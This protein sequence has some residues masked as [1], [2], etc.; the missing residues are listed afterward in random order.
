MS[1][2][3]LYRTELLGWD[4][5][6][7]GQFQGAQSVFSLPAIAVVGPT[8]RRCGARLTVHLGLASK[9]L[10]SMLT[11]RATRGWHFYA[12]V[13]AGMLSVSASS[14]LSAAHSVAGR[15]AGVAQGELQVSER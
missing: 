5:Q 1:F 3:E 10:V 11:L 6:Q 14:A 12:V 2:S 15:A 4:M 7:R 9:A 8:L 13:L